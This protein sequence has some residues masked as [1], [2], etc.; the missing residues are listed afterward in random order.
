MILLTVNE[1]NKPTDV[2]KPTENKLRRYV[3]KFGW[4]A[5]CSYLLCQL[6]LHLTIS[7]EKQRQTQGKLFSLTIQDNSTRAHARIER[8][9]DL[10]S[11]TDKPLTSS[12]RKSGD[13]S[14]D[15]E[16]PLQIDHNNTYWQRFCS[17]NGTFYLYKAFYDRRQSSTSSPSI[18][19][20]SMIDR[21]QPLSVYC[22]ISFE[23]QTIPSLVKATYTYI[24]HEKWGNHEDGILQPFIISCPLVST[25]HQPTNVSI[26]ETLCS[27]LTNRLSIIDKQSINQKKQSFVVCVKGLEYPDDDISFRLVEWIELIALL[28]AE[29]IFFY[30]FDIHPNISKTLRYY[31]DKQF[32]R[33]QEITLPGSQPNSLRARKA[34]LEQ[35][36]DSRR[37]NEV[38]PYNDC[39]Y[40]NI[41]L[42]EYVV[43][44]DIDEIIMPLQHHNW[45]QLIK[46]FTQRT[47]NLNASYAALL[48]RNIY[49]LENITEEIS[50]QSN[51]Q[52][53]DLSDIPTYLHM[54]RHIYRSSH[55]TEFGLYVKPFFDTKHVIAIHNHYPLSC[56]QD[57]VMK[58]ID[59][60]LV[61]LQHYRKDC[62]QPLQA[63]CNAEHRLNTTRDTTIWRYKTDLIR[64]TTLALQQLNLIV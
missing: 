8:R 61:H 59:I 12:H 35:K 40:E 56:F 33:V 38:I 45:S 24:W 19:I 7:D 9:I 42:Y 28:G 52:S 10:L 29:K 62:V 60:N 26:F 14:I 18:R 5:V 37:Q 55:H 44:L 31:Q 15:D 34:F 39:L 20:L 25:A 16:P 53:H 50:S 4:I 51:S 17:S 46:T 58:E 43:L 1:E 36:I 22:R 41:N 47:E 23:N 6:A 2:R 32:I 49:F 21:F 54:L 63:T 57:C 11:S 27:N 13:C 3:V 48:T 30:K 64:R